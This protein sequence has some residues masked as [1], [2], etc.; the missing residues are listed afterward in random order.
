MNTNPTSV[1]NMLLGLE[2]ADWVYQSFVKVHF[3]R[4]TTE[5]SNWL[6]SKIVNK[7]AEM[8]AMRKQFLRDNREKPDEDN[9][10]LKR[11]DSDDKVPIIEEINDQQKKKRLKTK[12]SSYILALNMFILKVDVK[13]FMFKNYLGFAG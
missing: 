9:Y 10:E 12:W 5:Y 7:E 13:T 11:R 1:M 2:M 8:V 6:V 3:H 4:M